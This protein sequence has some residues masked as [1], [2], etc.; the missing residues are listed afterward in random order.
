M[1][2]IAFGDIHMALGNFRNI[3]EIDKAD[4]IIITGDLTNYGTSKDAKKILDEVMRVN[5]KI[6]A[7]HGNLDEPEVGDYLADLGLSLHG[8]GKKINNIGIFGVGG[9]NITPFNTP[10]E[11]SED[12]LAGLLVKGFEQVK[13]KKSLIL[14]SHAPPF[15]TKADLLG[16]GAHV[17]SNAVR[18]F[19]EEIRPALCLTGHIHEA[20]SV[21]MIGDTMVV[22]PGMIKDDSWVEITVVHGVIKAALNH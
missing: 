5:K 16:S 9:S 17:G 22:N 20:R 1:R 2:I 8:R 19:I 6:L 7:L 12:E 13:N 10:T 3:P 18:E 11:F 4:L 14:V 15:N 21:D